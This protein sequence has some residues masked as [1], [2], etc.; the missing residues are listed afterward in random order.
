MGSPGRLAIQV[1]AVVL[2]LLVP[3]FACAVVRMAV[4]QDVLGVCDCPVAP[5]TRA[6][7]GVNEPR[8]VKSVQS[9]HAAR[10]KGTERRLGQRIALVNNSIVPRRSS[11]VGKCRFQVREIGDPHEILPIG[12]EVV[13]LNGRRG[14]KMI[15]ISVDSHRKIVHNRN[16]CSSIDKKSNMVRIIVKEID[17]VPNWQLK[18]N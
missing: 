4:P 3:F 8:S 11:K 15:D 17:W 12:G 10:Q 7:V 18:E 14:A 9:P 1:L 6:D 13:I 5:G 2:D 16:S